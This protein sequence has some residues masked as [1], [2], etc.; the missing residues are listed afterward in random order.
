MSLLELEKLKF[1]W[2]FVAPACK[3]T[4]GCATGT[5]VINVYTKKLDAP[6]ISQQKDS[7]NPH[8]VKARYGSLRSLSLAP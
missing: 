1:D 8:A 6:R 7:R 3:T 4:K 5:C 2:G